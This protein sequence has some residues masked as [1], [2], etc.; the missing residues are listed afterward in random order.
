MRLL[1]GRGTAQTERATEGAPAV[2][3]ATVAAATDCAEGRS[4]D[5]SLPIHAI[6]H[7]PQVLLAP[8]SPRHDHAAAPR[9]RRAVDALRGASR[10]RQVFPRRTQY[11]SCRQCG[12][13]VP[14]HVC[15]GSARIS[16]YGLP[17]A[18]DKRFFSCFGRFV[19]L[20]ASH[21]RLESLC[22]SRGFAVILPTCVLAAI[23]GI[24]FFFKIRALKSFAG[25]SPSVASILTALCRPRHLQYYVP[26]LRHYDD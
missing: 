10:L 22:D 4:A 3:R 25:P 18:P 15:V 17:L 8:H 1:C 5:Y 26:Y 9:H 6:L 21:S 7:I 20:L 24:Y 23:I 14:T 16:L 11:A 12:A 13:S 19:A 2:H